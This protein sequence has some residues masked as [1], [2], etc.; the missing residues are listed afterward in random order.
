MGSKKSKGKAKRR[1]KVGKGARGQAQ[2]NRN[3]DGYY[4]YMPGTLLK[5]DFFPEAQP[6]RRDAALHAGGAAD[7][8]APVKTRS[9]GIWRA[10]SLNRQFR[11][12]P[13]NADV[14]RP[15]LTCTTFM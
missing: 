4:P 8:L 3:K 13:D 2:E 11:S 6:G 15:A 7:G 12:D 14:L 9:G 5:V 1:N 10:L